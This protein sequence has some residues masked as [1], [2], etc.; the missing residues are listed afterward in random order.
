MYTSE[1]QVSQRRRVQNSEE[2]N[3][4]SVQARLPWQW[5]QMQRY[6]Q[7]SPL[8]LPL[9]FLSCEL[10]ISNA[11]MKVSVVVIIKL[12]SH[13]VLYCIASYRIALYC[14][15]FCCIV[16]YLIVLC[17][18]VFIFYSLFFNLLSFH[19]IKS[20]AYMRGLYS[21]ARLQQA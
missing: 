21:E 1:N 9:P 8:V 10:N 2:K 7:C 13:I 4:M 18:I 16:L 20:N 5:T 6:V 11:Q 14:V 15:L 12:H 19:C 17:F 3:S